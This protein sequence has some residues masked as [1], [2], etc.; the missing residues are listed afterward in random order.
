[1]ALDAI[2][3]DRQEEELPLVVQEVVSRS[4]TQRGLR[5]PH[6]NVTGAMIELRGYHI[7]LHCHVMGW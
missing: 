7:F 3:E 2:H 4:N 6:C 1:V 5:N